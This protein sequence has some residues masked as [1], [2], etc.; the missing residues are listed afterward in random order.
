LVDEDTQPQGYPFPR[1]SSQ[2]SSQSPGGFMRSAKISSPS[3]FLSESPRH[4]GESAVDIHSYEYHAR[5]KTL[6]EIRSRRRFSLPTRAPTPA[7]TSA[8]ANMGPFVSQRRAG[9][10][11]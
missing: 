3:V 4:R 6:Q 11:G 7:S 2:L 8:R 10:M 1:S 5:P 9:R